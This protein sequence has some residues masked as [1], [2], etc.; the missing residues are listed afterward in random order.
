MKLSLGA[1]KFPG[2]G[3]Q[4]VREAQI[5]HLSPLLLS[6][7]SQMLSEAQVQMRDALHVNRVPSARCRR[8]WLRTEQ[9]SSQQEIHGSFTQ[10]P[11]TL[12]CLQPGPESCGLPVSNNRTLGVHVASHPKKRTTSFLTL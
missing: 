3:E 6:P 5:F 1:L 10:I 2:S 7:R 11:H 4:A 12:R 8:A 9:D